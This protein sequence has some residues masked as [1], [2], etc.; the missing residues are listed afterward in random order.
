MTRKAIGAFILL[1]V[2]AAFHGTPPRAGELAAVTRLEDAGQGSLLFKGDD[3]EPLLVAPL[4]GTDVSIT[5]SGLIARA[6]VVQRFFNPGDRWVEGVY[7]FPLPENAA[8]DHLTMRIGERVIEGRIKERAE[9]RQIYEAAKQEG[10]KSGL[11]EH[12]RPNIFTTSIA[13]IG[14]GEEVSIEIE[15]QQILEYD[16]GRFPYAFPWSSAR[17]ISPAKS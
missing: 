5:V 2:L 15:Y 13:N 7:V 16:R 6:H 1:F 4:V 9:A 12:E 3:G 14:P 8:V 10:R 11:I 17:A